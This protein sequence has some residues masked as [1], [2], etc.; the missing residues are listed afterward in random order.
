LVD[1]CAKRLEYSG[2]LKKFADSGMT[3]RIVL[4]K[5]NGLTRRIK[6]FVSQPGQKQPPSHYEPVRAHLQRELCSAIEKSPA[7]FDTIVR[8]LIQ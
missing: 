8:N 1:L 3:I 5:S 4:D 7:S 2:V 6:A